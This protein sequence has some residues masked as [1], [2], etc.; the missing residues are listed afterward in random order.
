MAINTSHAVPLRNA[1][2][3]LD[4]IVPSDVISWNPLLRLTKHNLTRS[5]AHSILSAL[6]AVAFILTLGFMTQAIKT[7]MEETEQLYNETIVEM[8]IYRRD[9]STYLDYYGGGFIERQTF[10]ALMDSGFIKDVYWEATSFSQYISPHPNVD[11]E[12]LELIFASVRSSNNIRKLI[13]DHSLQ[14]TFAEGWDIETFEQASTDEFL[15]LIIPLEQFTQFQ[16]MLNEEFLFTSSNCIVA[17]VYTTTNVGF[18]DY[19]TSATW[20]FEYAQ[21]NLVHYGYAYDRAEF[22]IDPAKNRELDALYALTDSLVETGGIQPLHF[23]YWDE[24][25]TSVVRPLEQSLQLLNILYPVVMVVSILV[26]IGLQV[27]LLIQ[28]L[29]TA[30]LLRVLGVPVSQTGG[31]LTLLQ[32]PAV[33]L[34]LVLGL[35][36]LLILYRTCDPVYAA[37]YLGGSLAGILLGLIRMAKQQPLELLQVKE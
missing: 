2:T 28:Q 37:M 15:P 22:T 8:D 9:S 36:I 27:I 1:S 31:V 14:I 10:D 26:A 4:V 5:Y 32:L 24:E 7:N 21:N 34:G 6:V 13:E 16:L 23:Q 35:G 29:R 11:T 30:A 19:L 18:D 25:L 12:K 17:G 33:V 3:L 20:L